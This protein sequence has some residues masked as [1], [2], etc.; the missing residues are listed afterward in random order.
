M[1]SGYCADSYEQLGVMSPGYCV[2]RCEHLG[3][4]ALKY[5]VSHPNVQICQAPEYSVDRFEH[6]FT[7]NGPPGLVLTDVNIYL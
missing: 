5:S 1:A 4:M 6:Y 7:Y 3:V 2:D